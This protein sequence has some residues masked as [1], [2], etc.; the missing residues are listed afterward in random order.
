M[1]EALEKTAEALERLGSGWGRGE[2]VE[3]LSV[4]ASGVISAVAASYAPTV[5]AAAAIAGLYALMA[6][7]HGTWRAFIKLW[8]ASAALATPAILLAFT[9]RGEAST[10]ASFTPSVTPAGA[11]AALLTFMRV[12]GAAAPTVAA[13]VYLGAG[14]IASAL[15]CVPGASWLSTSLRVF[16]ATLPQI[17]RHLSRLLLAREARSFIRRASLSARASAVGDMLVASM[18]YSRNVA[19]A[20]RARDFGGH[21]VRGGKPSLPWVL[22]GAMSVAAY[23]AGVAGWLQGLP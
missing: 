14:G 8:S 3:A 20:F 11:Y 5:T 16:S 18:R 13:A 21:T 22:A 1:R 23:I 7:A 19:L 6:I 15:D 12:W 4:F 10:L 17:L 2:C 9:P